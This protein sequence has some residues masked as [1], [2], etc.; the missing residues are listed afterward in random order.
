MWHLQSG[1]LAERGQ[2][3]R[4]RL[5]PC[6]SVA[7]DRL[8]A[9][10]AAPPQPGSA[11]TIV[12]RRRAEPAKR[13]ARTHGRRIPAAWRIGS[14][15]RA[16]ASSAAGGSGAHTARDRTP[17]RLPAARGG[18]GASDARGSGR[19]TPG[20]DG[21]LSGGEQSA[22]RPDVPAT[23]RPRPLSRTQRGYCREPGTH[24]PRGDGCRDHG[25][26]SR[27]RR[28][29][30]RRGNPPPRRVSHRQ[31]YDVPFLGHRNSR[32]PLKF[33]P[34]PAARGRSSFRAH[35]VP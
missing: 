16:P 34:A 10:D 7:E 1:Q 29:H 3:A 30:L 8:R 21:E 9:T 11:A 2:G 33:R 6:G 19:T 5:W 24:G 4:K 17:P 13:E 20:L 22:K 25:N 27:G 12:R 32:S 28:T 35:R 15:R 14:A 26:Y 31:G 23:R 18:F